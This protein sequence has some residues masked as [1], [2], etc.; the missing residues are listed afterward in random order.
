MTYQ[1]KSSKNAKIQKRQNRRVFQVGFY[2]LL[3]IPEGDY[4]P[5]RSH[6]TVLATCCCQQHLRF[7]RNP[8]E[9]C[10][11]MLFSLR[12]RTEQLHSRIET[13]NFAKNAALLK[14][15]FNQNSWPNPEGARS[16]DMEA[17]K[18]RS[19]RRIPQNFRRSVL[20]YPY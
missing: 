14:F 10:P 11:E 15:I 13:A 2:L 20:R 9:T 8:R 18:K 7:L 3:P 16:G 1:P 6:G 17:R 5:L 4:P 12:T 19:F